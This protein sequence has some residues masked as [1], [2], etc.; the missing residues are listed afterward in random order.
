M[1]SAKPS[2]LA[3][4]L[5]DTAGAYSGFYQNLPFLKAPDGVRESRIRLGRATGGVLRRG[6]NLLGI[7]TPERI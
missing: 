4:Y 3:D 5:Y 2:L 6:L 7:E 1:S